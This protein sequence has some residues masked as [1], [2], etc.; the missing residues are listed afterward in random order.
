MLMT[1]T[2]S[3]RANQALRA[4]S[5]A[6]LLGLL[7]VATAC[8]ASDSAC[9]DGLPCTT[10]EEVDGRCL[11]SPK[12]CDDHDPCTVDFCQASDGACLH[13]VTAGCSVGPDACGDGYCQ[14]G[15]GVASCPADCKEIVNPETCGDGVCDATGG[16]TRG[17]CPADCETVTPRPCGD[18]AC[19]A[20][21]GETHDTCPADCA[22]PAACGDK[23]CD[24]GE[25]ATSC[26][27]DCP[28]APSCG[29]DTCSGAETSQSCPEDCPA[30]DPCGDGICSAANGEDT[31][32]C[33]KDCKDSPAPVCG[34]DK[35][36]A[37][38]SASS[39]PEDCATTG[40]AS[41]ADC[42]DGDPC[43]TDSCDGAT[44]TCQHDAL[45]NCPA[46]DT[47][48]LEGLTLFKDGCDKE[49]WGHWTNADDFAINKVDVLSKGS[50]TSAAGA[51]VASVSYAV[52][53]GFTQGF[54]DVW[55]FFD[56]GDFPD[57]SYTLVVVFADQPDLILDLPVVASFYE[58]DEWI[59]LWEWNAFD[60][61]KLTLRPW[62][63]GRIQRVDVYDEDR[64]LMYWW[65]WASEPAFEPNELFDLTLPEFY[66]TSGTEILVVIQG[67]DD[68]LYYTFYQTMRV[69]IP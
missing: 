69:P 32:T 26:P 20:S 17:T 1:T 19:D 65:T 11:H 35:C 25:T 3:R 45:S 7:A 16:E 13:Q 50:A 43:T 56:D 47:H 58:D 24:P 57:D 53:L 68:S 40:C 41:V 14:T 34:D 52:G 33:P 9:D 23:H 63:N 8:G 44:G 55:R 54:P 22:A 37:G 4:L 29:D 2:G 31:S 15:E 5:L 42:D 6:G 21:A 61:L 59:D 62:F 66:P 51:V 36:D 10:D 18:G 48:P 67:L 46:V 27:V 28:L 12:T 64:C 60:A 30:P 38:E 39:C 49:L